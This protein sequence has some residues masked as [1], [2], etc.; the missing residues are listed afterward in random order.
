M[1]KRARNGVRRADHMSYL[2]G[3]YIYITRILS[4]KCELTLCGLGAI[5]QSRPGPSHPHSF[6]AGIHKRMDNVAN[7]C[8]NASH[9]PHTCMQSPH[10]RTCAPACAREHA[11]THTYT[12]TH[13]HTL[14]LTHT[15]T[16]TH[17]HARTRTHARARARARACVRA[18]HYLP[19]V[20]EC[21]LRCT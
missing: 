19:D 20:Q 16:H 5:M 12:H 14:S 15:H 10:L 3:S 8:I 17:T 1:S 9:G 21:R 11:C 13:T 6:A 18:E 4:G 7:T 2:K